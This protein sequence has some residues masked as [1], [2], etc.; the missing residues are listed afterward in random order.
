MVQHLLPLSIFH[1]F[2][3]RAN[4]NQNHL[5]TGRSNTAR[6][7]ALQALNAII[8]KVHNKIFLQSVYYGLA[9]LKKSIDTV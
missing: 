5:N 6:N 4:L 7:T 3:K 1:T 2:S 8:L 9:L